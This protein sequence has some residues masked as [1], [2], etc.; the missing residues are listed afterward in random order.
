VLL[1]LFFL[2][3][4]LAYLPEAAL[5]AIIF[6]IGVELVDIK[7]MRRIY[8][9]RRSEF[10]IALTTALTVV[11][12]GVEQSILLAIT[13]SL[14]DHTRQGY[15]PHNA[16]LIRDAHGIK[17][18]PLGRLKDPNHQPVELEPGLIVYRFSHSIY[19]ANT[20]MLFSQVTTLA[21][22]AVPKISWFCIDA[23]AIDDVDYTGAVT[24]RS[25][26]DILKASNIRLMFVQVSDDVR[27]TLE[28]YELTGL[29]GAE[30]F[31]DSIGNVLHAYEKCEKGAARS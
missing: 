20:E 30:C 25:I 29:V 28:A 21:T 31:F 12:V 9:A 13:L 11:C 10:W 3:G 14:L 2:T 16:V 15:R 8:R 23:A 5:A 1:V 22:N 4:P 26:H 6:L 19:Y 7:G 24:L 17:S 27:Q 18:L